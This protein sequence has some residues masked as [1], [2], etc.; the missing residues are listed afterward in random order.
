LENVA[1]AMDVPAAELVAL[2]EAIEQLSIED[3]VSA[4]IVKLRFFGG[5]SHSEAASALGITRRVADRHWAYA[6]AWLYAHLQK[7]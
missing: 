7:E 2:D 5:L 1:V 3:S 6:R 4:E